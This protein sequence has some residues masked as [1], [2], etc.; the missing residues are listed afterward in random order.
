MPKSDVKTRILHRLD[1]KTDL[2]AWTPIDFLD[3]GRRDVVDKVLQRLAHAN[4]IQRIDRGLYFKPR[5][6]RLTGVPTNPD[7]RKIVAALARRDQTR[8]LIDGLTAANDLGLT[9]AVPARVVIHTDARLKPLR[10]GKLDVHFKQT[11]PSKLYWAGRPAMKV[12]QALHWLRDTLPQD[13]ARIIRRLH[14]ILH[15]PKHGKRLRND[16]RDG[17]PTLPAWMQDLVREVLHPPVESA[18]PVPSDITR[19]TLDKP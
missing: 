19:P 4:K 7:Y 8:M 17:L 5:L 2:G 1:A 18:K 15:D 12:V 10:L 9:D 3:V 13:K 6:N 11:A 16:L 14:A